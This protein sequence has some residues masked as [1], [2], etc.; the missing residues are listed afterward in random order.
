MHICHVFYLLMCVL[1]HVL[2]ILSGITIVPLYH[3]SYLAALEPG[4]LA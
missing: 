1:F 4:R 3:L 2:S